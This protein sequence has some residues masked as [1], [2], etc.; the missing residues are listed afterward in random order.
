VSLQAD[1]TNIGIGA[2]AT[3]NSILGCDSLSSVSKS[4]LNPLAQ[5]LD[6]D[7]AVFMRFRM[8]VLNDPLV[9][10]AVY[11]GKN[12]GTL[13]EY[14]A[15]HFSEDPI[16]QPLRGLM[17]RHLGQKD[18]INV[19]L[20]TQLKPGALRS[21]DYFRNFLQPNDLSDVIG[22]VFPVDIDGPQILALGIHR[23]TEKPK[24]T[25]IHGLALNSLSRALGTVFR[26]ICLQSSLEE[27]QSVLQSLE[28]P[29]ESTDFAVF[30]NK[31]RLLR[32]SGHFSQSARSQGREYNEV[33][34]TLKSTIANPNSQDAADGAGLRSCSLK[35][36]IAVRWRR[37][38]N[39][40]GAQYV[41]L[42]NNSHEVVHC[43][44]EPTGYCL[45][46]LDVLTTREREVV[47]QVALGLRNSDIGDTLHI[48]VRT[49]EN[50]LRSVFDKLAI[51]SRTQLVNSLYQS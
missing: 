12:P 45:G 1:T 41:V 47:E 36:G 16:L 20:G 31:L 24:F 25:E 43:R 33:L 15:G 27:Q 37:V 48:S 30:D 26:N 39:G 6:A 28:I 35:C 4:V 5:L 29:S 22:L 17:E 40:D 11:A 42:M 3:I 9:C 49:V 21:T 14:L 13:D 10:D 51:N 18:P 2:S 50:H 8:D 34:Q 32:A 38:G 19:H 44:S 23:N 46:I 7:S